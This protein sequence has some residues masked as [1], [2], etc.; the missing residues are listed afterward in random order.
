ME[1]F[2]DIFISE[3]LNI[4]SLLLLYF[5]GFFSL[6]HWHLSQTSELFLR[7]HCDFMLTELQVYIVFLVLG[8]NLIPQIN[9]DNVPIAQLSSKRDVLSQWVCL[10][11]ENLKPSYYVA[12]AWYLTDNFTLSKRILGI[13]RAWIRLQNRVEKLPAAYAFEFF[14][15]VVLYMLKEVECSTAWSS[16]KSKFAQVYLDKNF[17]LELA[18]VLNL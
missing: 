13:T 6:E 2:S 3:L 4:S 1:A 5:F 8:K 15:A 7:L 9:G 16:Y 12:I 10:Y 14:R 11:I 17:V 18:S